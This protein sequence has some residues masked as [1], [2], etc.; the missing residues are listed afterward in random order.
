MYMLNAIVMTKKI[1][2]EKPGDTTDMLFKTK[3]QL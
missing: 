1:S 3:C 2:P